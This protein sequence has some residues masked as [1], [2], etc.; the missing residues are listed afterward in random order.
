[1]SAWASFSAGEHEPRPTGC[2]PLHRGNPAH[3]RCL[4]ASYR[5]DMSAATGY[6]ANPPLDR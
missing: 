3:V 2:G 4:P 5:M 6:S 1:M